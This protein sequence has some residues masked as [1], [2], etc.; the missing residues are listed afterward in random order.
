MSAKNSSLSLQACPETWIKT[1]ELAKRLGVS[2]RTIQRAVADG[3][4]PA[5]AKIRRSVR[6]PLSLVADI[7]QRVLSRA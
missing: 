6:W 4:F 1:R 2:V 5:P 7:E 3:T